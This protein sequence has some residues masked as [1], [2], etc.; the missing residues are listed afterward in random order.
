MKGLYE[1]VEAARR[2]G[3]VD[4][5]HVSPTSSEMGPLWDALP[6]L[7]PHQHFTRYVSVISEL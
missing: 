3:V 2:S 5:H 7:L 4:P 1:Y 6:P